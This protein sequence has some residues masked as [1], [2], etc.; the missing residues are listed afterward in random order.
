[1]LEGYIYKY[2][3]DVRAT[4]VQRSHH[5]MIYMLLPNFDVVEGADVSEVDVGV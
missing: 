3:N 4:P 5:C 2:N 1:M